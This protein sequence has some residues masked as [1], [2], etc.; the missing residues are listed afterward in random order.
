MGLYLKCG[1]VI[2]KAT[3]SFFQLD[4]AVMASG[5]VENWLGSL[6][7]ETLHSVHVVI[8][9]AWITIE[10]PNFQLI[11]FLNSYPAQVCIHKVRFTI[12]VS[13]GFGDNLAAAC[14]VIHVDPTNLVCVY[15][16]HWHHK[17]YKIHLCIS[18]VTY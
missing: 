18:V 13:G 11:E 15:V 4:K 5:N 6:L 16:P 14:C 2:K 12:L 7:K 8:K 1:Q 10:D 17:S 9:N 3:F